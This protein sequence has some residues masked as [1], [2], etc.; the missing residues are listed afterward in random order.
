MKKRWQNLREKTIAKT[1]RE[2]LIVL[3]L[4]VAVIY[5]IANFGFIFPL[6]QK[7]EQLDVRLSAIEIELKKLTAQEKVIAAALTNDPNAV[8]KREILQL[9]EQM[10]DLDKDLQTL[11]VGLIPADKLPEAL[12][13]VLSS[14]GSLKLLGMET[15]AATRLSLQEEQVS[16]LVV[17]SDEEDIVTLVDEP[18]MRVP[19]VGVFKHSVEVVLEG[20]YFDLIDY[21]QALENLTWKIYWEAL[22][23]EVT[24]YPK[25]KIKLEVYTLSTEEGVLGV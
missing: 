14:I 18:R 4:I 11:S 1:L 16:D 17:E 6:E 10:L 25:A 20:K 15:L 9:E 2:R 22:D 24:R 13:A 21:L 12:H 5:G 23:Y 3:F 19:T 8:K 7:R